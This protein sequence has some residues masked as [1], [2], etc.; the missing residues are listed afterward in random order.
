M[1]ISNLCMY[2]YVLLTGCH[3]YLF[4]TYLNQPKGCLPSDD[5]C[6][7]VGRLFQTE[8][9]MPCWIPS[10][11]KQCSSQDS[12]KASCYYSKVLH[13]VYLHTSTGI[14]QCWY[15]WWRHE[16]RTHW[17][18]QTSCRPSY[19]SIYARKG[20]KFVFIINITIVLTTNVVIIQKSLQ[21]TQFYIHNIHVYIPNASHTFL[22]T[23]CADTHPPTDATVTCNT[24]SSITT[25]V[26]CHH[27]YHLHHHQA[28]HHLYHYQCWKLFTI[29]IS[30]IITIINV[31]VSMTTRTILN[32]NTGCN[33]VHSHTCM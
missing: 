19:L 4:A 18:V 6:V 23:C 26:E 5:T 33:H 13:T 2:V 1:C 21:T 8:K 31:S 32:A 3:L 22:W 16:W 14:R 9:S 10:S 27:N 28:H 20:A 25:E 11:L 12:L 24:T 17:S 15:P 7:S 29:I 30:H